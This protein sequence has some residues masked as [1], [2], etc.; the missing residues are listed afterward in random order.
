MNFYKITNKKE[1]HNKMKYKTGLNE[2]I[3][4]FNPSGDC[5]SGGIY[6]SREDILAFLSYGPWIRKVFIPENAIVYENPENP[7]K[8][9]SNKVILGEKEKINKNVIK[10]LIK[11]G[12]NPKSYNICPLRWALEDNNLEIAKLLFSFSDIEVFDRCFR[13]TEERNYLEIVKLLTSLSDPKNVNN[14]TFYYEKLKTYLK[15]SN[16]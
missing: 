1:W 10:R 3:V 5:E 16:Y 15:M 13:S 7:K 14:Y 4:I 8:W 2:D 11:E 9:K 12:A 6:F